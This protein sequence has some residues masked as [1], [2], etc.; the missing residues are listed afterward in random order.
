[1]DECLQDG[2][3]EEIMSGTPF[4]APYAKITRT[5]RQIEEIDQAVQSF[6]A[7]APFEITSRVDAA[8]DEQIWSFKL[9]TNLPPDISVQAGEVI[10][11]LRSSL[12]QMLVETITHHDSGTE[13]GIEFPFGQTEEKFETSLKK[14][15]KRLPQNAPEMIRAFRPFAGGDA[16]L[17]LLHRIN[18][19]DKH[20]PGLIAI[21]AATGGMNSYISSFDGQ[22]LTV[23]SR[24]GQHLSVSRRMSEAEL[25]EAKGAGKAV[26]MYGTARLDPRTGLPTEAPIG[27]AIYANFATGDAASTFDFAVTTPGT[28][29][30]TDF[31]PMLNIAFL[32]AEGI[33]NAPLVAVLREIRT[34]VSNILNQFEG[35]FFT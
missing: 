14:Q 22:I 35:A 11:N 19:I 4:A 20:R 31:Q 12:D 29:I 30:V 17:W 25:A 24:N 33:G 7:S 6:A 2:Y 16:Y 8:A 26:N 1:M 3:S 21:N 32:N 9:K 13:A 28:R 34:K 23:G 18:R 15:L 27:R 10:H 5:E